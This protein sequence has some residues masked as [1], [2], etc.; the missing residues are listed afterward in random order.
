MQDHGQV[1]RNITG[2][3]HIAS[4][5]S[6]LSPPSIFQ[7]YL[8]ATPSSWKSRVLRLELHTWDMSSVPAQTLLPR[9]CM[10]NILFLL[11]ILIL[12]KLLFQQ[13]LDTVMLWH[14][15]ELSDLRKPSPSC[16]EH[17]WEVG[18]RGSETLAC[19]TGKGRQIGHYP[20]PSTVMW[21][22]RRGL[23]GGP[24]TK[25]KSVQDV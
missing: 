18:A 15:S 20:S 3:N 1:N 17:S 13:C 23:M 22:S 9:V 21:I 6:I 10:G 24:K 16:E 12:T 11:L 7:I 14:E 19:L 2:A 5:K 8:L 25:N 4:P